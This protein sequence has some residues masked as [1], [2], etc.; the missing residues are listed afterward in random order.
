MSIAHIT[1]QHIRQHVS[2]EMAAQA[3]ERALVD[4]V[5]P[6]E[7][8]PRNTY[9]LKDHN[10]LMFM[11]SQSS[12]W[13][14]AKFMSV[15]PGNPARRLDRAQGFY[16]LMD[17]DT[18]TPK[19]L[20]D[21]AELT[22]LRTV[23]VTALVTR[24][25]LGRDA[26]RAV[27]YGYGAQA[28]A[29]AIGLRQLHPQLKNLVVHGR[30]PR[31]AEMFAANAAEHGWNARIGDAMAPDVAVP[32]ADLVITATG[33]AE[34]LFP[35]SLI[36]P[37]TLVVALGSHNAHNHE[38][39][40]ELMGRSNVIVE[41]IDTALR[42]AGEVALAVEAGLLSTDDLITVRDVV[43]GTAKIDRNKPTVYKTVGMSWQDLI[44]AGEV[45]ARVPKVAL[46]S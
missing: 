3:L 44:V 37:G 15:N 33:A 43:R 19:A 30:D 35:A 2:Y 16:I 5:E 34:P 12:H 38:L 17:A 24:K 32:G 25:L 6:A 45:Y 20:I 11:A 28:R 46:R 18:T 4:D 1:E 9:P 10:Y 7:D 22:D 13:V 42:E 29:H 23:A 31:R 8:F 36:Q 39:D 21:G 26:E 41:D 27:L 40:L 14:G